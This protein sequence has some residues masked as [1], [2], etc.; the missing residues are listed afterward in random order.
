MA[1]VLIIESEPV[2]A[3]IFQIYLAEHEVM[4]AHSALS[5]LELL[6]V[7]SPDIVVT[8]A[9]LPD[10]GRLGILSALQVASEKPVIVIT[11]G[12][13]WTEVSD[14]V[15]SA[16]TMGAAIALRKPVS[17]DVLRLAVLGILGLD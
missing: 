9:E 14:Y 7:H 3:R 12:G 10:M 13:P 5:G 6:T 17:R 15:E 11:A 2:I 8:E 1:K 4:V 16:M